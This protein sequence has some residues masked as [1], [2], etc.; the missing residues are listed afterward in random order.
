MCLCTVH[1]MHALGLACTFYIINSSLLAWHF[2]VKGKGSWSVEYSYIYL[3]QLNFFRESHRG[4]GDRH[5][6]RETG[7]MY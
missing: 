7:M 4:E 5:F 1:I 6:A 2:I 3:F